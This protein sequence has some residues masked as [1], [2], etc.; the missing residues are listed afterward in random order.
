MTTNVLNVLPSA[1]GWGPIRA[2]VQY[3][4]G[5]GSKCLGDITVQDNAGNFSFF[6]ATATK[7]FKY[8]TT[9]SS[10]VDVTR[11]SGGNYATPSNHNWSFHQFGSG[12]YACNGSD[13]NQYFDINSSSN[14]TAMPVDAASPAIP[15]ARYVSSINEFLI[16]IGTGDGNRFTNWSGIG[17]PNWWKPRERGSGVQEMPDGGELTGF[18]AYETGGIL[19]QR[20]KM[21]SMTFAPSSPFSFTFA[22]VQNR[23]GA[24]GNASVLPFR[25]TFYFLSDSGFFEGVG[26]TPIGDQRVNK[27]LYE[28]ADLTKLPETHGAVDLINKIA[29]WV[30]T[31]VDQTTELLGYHW[32]LERWT[33]ADFDAD[34]IAGAATPGSTLEGLDAF[35]NMDTLGFSLDSRVWV[36]GVLGIAGFSSTGDFGFFEGNN[37]P[38]VIETN[39]TLVS[40]SNNSFVQSIRLITDADISDYTGRVDSRPNPGADKIVGT[41]VSPSNI[42][43]KMLTRATGRTHRTRFEITEGA[44]WSNLVGVELVYTK[45]GSR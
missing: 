40:K 6:A 36:G 3:G 19:L 2:F 9:T 26:G 44:V 25:N 28:I 31:K 34:Y 8:D 42:S 12:L 35:G 29:W 23:I 37:L 10:F 16:L 11:T 14:F 27:Y 45:A 32:V 24:L 13:D 1:D 39:D 18:V 22:V 5:L 4:N 15:V 33:R 17:L 30:I 43:G 20:S 7:I 38:V 21:R 41:D